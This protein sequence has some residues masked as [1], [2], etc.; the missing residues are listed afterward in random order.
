MKAF[1]GLDQGLHK[2]DGVDFFCGVLAGLKLHS[3][4]I[5]ARDKGIYHEKLSIRLFSSG[6]GTRP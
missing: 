3:K 5:F 4:E 2:F 6:N 1:T